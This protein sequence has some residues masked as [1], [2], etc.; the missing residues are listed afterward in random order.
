MVGDGDG[1]GRAW[2]GKSGISCVEVGDDGAAT[3]SEAG[4]GEVL[5]PYAWRAR[6]WQWTAKP[7]QH[8][9]FVRA[10]DQHGNAQPVEQPWTYQGMGNNMVQRVLV[11]V[12]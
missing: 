1:N 6:S 11:L 8:T 9:L 7:G 2:A 4:L 12:E 10:T 3:W 5:A